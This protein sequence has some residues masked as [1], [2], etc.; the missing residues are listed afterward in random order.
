MSNYTNVL[1]FTDKLKCKFIFINNRNY[2]VF[3]FQGKNRIFFVPSFINFSIEKDSMKFEY[4]KNN[5]S[6]LY[7]FTSFYSF[8]K[9]YISN[10]EKLYRK[11][12]ILKGLGLKASFSEDNKNLILKLGFSHAVN[13][14]IPK[15][16]AIQIQK[17]I[18]TIQSFDKVLVGNFAHKLRSL[19]TLDRYKGKGIWYNNEIISLKE[20]KKS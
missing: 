3:H 15:E 19:R 11:K 6:K 12:L 13:V 18:I 8:I 17:N 16:I 5:D 2:L 7:E 4:N 14:L 10:F 1:K 20:V 9:T